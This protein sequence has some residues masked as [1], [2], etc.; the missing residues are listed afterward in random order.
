LERRH[1]WNVRVA[2]VDNPTPAVSRMPFCWSD[3]DNRHAAAFRERFALAEAIE[4]AAD[5]WD[6]IL[7]LRHWVF[8]NMINHTNAALPGLEP[9][10]T[11]DP[12][13][14]VTASHAGGTFWCSHFSMVMVAAATSMGFVARKLSVDCEHTPQEKGCH[15][16]VVDAWVGRFRKWVHLD[17][18]YDHHYELDGVPLS[19]EEIG[20]RWQTHRGE[21]IQ[22]VVGPQRRP[23][24]RARVGKRG[25]PDACAYFWHLIE[26]RN[27]VFRR[28]GRGSKAMAV[29][30]VDEARKGQRWTQGT[31]PNTFEKRGYGD[32][33]LQ[34][35][36]DLADAYP[37]VDAAWMNLLGPH[38]MPYY[39]RAQLSTPCAPFFSHYEVRVDEGPAQRVMGVE[40]PWRLHPGTCRI[41]A[42]TVDVAG[43][44]G[45]PYRIGL[46]IEENP[47]ASPQRPWPADA[48][49]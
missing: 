13:A 32:G 30:L 6:A 23:V 4:G 19:A 15:H 7:R 33:T 21:G 3:Y 42:R 29:M 2:E 9:F 22:A 12:A 25:L 26:C 39:C 20:R 14:L 38:K 37:D 27:D 35:T 46:E 16:G 18:N 48:N 36:E 34:I 11:L 28:D 47:S 45:P 17:P 40:Y 8:V 41:E 31:P 43:H 10:S 44:R 5:H 24:A 1:A 49:G